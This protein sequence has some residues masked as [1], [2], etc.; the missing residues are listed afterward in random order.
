MY[1]MNTKQVENWFYAGI[2]LTLGVIATKTV[3]NFVRGM[4]PVP[5]ADV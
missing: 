4:V 2:G 5:L 1:H 3:V